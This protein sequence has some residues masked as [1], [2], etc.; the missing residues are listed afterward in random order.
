LY[1]GDN[2]SGGSAVT[3]VNRNRNNTA[4]SGMSMVKASTVTPAGT[5][6]DID[7]FGTTGNPTARTGG[8]A[9]ANEELVLKPSTKYTLVLTPAG[10]TVVNAKLFW[11]EEDYGV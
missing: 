4:V 9:G 5:L 11:Y 3:P 8:G 6:I 7:G 1:E 2:Y 10:A